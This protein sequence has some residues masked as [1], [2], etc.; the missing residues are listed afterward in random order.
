MTDYE[1]QRAIAF[2]RTGPPGDPSLSEQE[3]SIKDW[4]RDNGVTIV[5]WFFEH[6]Q[7]NEK[8][9][10]ILSRMLN[11]LDRCGIPLLIVHDQPRLSTSSAQMGEIIR[12]IIPDHKLII[13]TDWGLSE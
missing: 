11:T 2:I 5:S 3:M 10:R 1:G 6:S 13:A 8:P 12:R 9:R 7:G 4:A